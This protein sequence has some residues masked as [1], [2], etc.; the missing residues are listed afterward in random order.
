[1]LRG[2]ARRVLGTARRSLFRSVFG[3]IAYANLRSEQLRDAKLSSSLRRDGVAVL[4][5]I[6]IEDRFESFGDSYARTLREW[7]ER[8]LRGWPK[9]GRRGFDDRFRRMWDDYLAYCEVGFRTGAVDV[10]FFKLVR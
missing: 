9:I 5:V 7:R 1:M 10:G 3:A 4:R 8:F 6:T 2:A